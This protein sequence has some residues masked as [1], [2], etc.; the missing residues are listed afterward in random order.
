MPPPPSPYVRAI[1]TRTIT[2][3]TIHHTH[4]TD[5]DPLRKAYLYVSMRTV[6]KGSRTHSTSTTAS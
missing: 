6:R 4:K 3:Q 2:R 5:F 1:A